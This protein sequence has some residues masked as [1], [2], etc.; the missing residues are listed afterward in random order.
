MRWV[1]EPSQLPDTLFKLTVFPNPQ[2]IAQ[3]GAHFR[4][5]LERVFPRY[6][7]ALLT[8]TWDALHALD[9]VQISFAEACEMGPAVDDPGPQSFRT[10]MIVCRHVDLDMYTVAGSGL[11]YIEQSMRLMLKERNLP[12][13]DL[14]SRLSKGLQHAVIG[15]K[16]CPLYS[17]C[18]I[19]PKDIFDMPAIPKRKIEAVDAVALAEQ[20]K[21]RLRI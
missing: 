2:G 17:Q 5:V 10:D 20:R 12:S 16:I 1:W 8:R 6:P 3:H 9:Q 18:R 21:K 13:K 4:N 11:E 15:G 7:K 14:R 19:G